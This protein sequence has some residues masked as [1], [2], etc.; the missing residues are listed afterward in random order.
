MEDYSHFVSEVQ[1]QIRSI[2]DIGPRQEEL[3]RAKALAIRRLW[4][5]PDD[6]EGL[7]RFSYQRDLAR[8][9]SSRALVEESLRGV[10]VGQVRE[11]AEGLEL[12]TVFFLHNQYN[13]R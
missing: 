12:D 4:S 1:Y 8:A 11:V 13:Q 3:D 7:A 6:R 2:C 9:Q 10:G 5:L